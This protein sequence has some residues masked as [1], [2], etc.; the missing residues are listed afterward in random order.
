[1]ALR[2]KIDPE[3]LLLDEYIAIESG[4]ILGVMV[5]DILARFVVDET[6]NY[7]AED[8]ARKLVGR[9]SVK[10]L[11]QAVEVLTESLRDLAVPPATGGG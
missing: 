8:E 1:M 4:T 9:R 3:L 5:R 7:L 2:F 11:R 10:E 6:D